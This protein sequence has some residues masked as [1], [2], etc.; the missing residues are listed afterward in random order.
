MP[1]G[2]AADGGKAVLLPRGGEVG[3]QCSGKTEHEQEA[4]KVGGGW[5]QAKAGSGSEGQGYFLWSHHKI[6]STAILL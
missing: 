6:N 2:Q 3:T 1:P 4:S 5:G